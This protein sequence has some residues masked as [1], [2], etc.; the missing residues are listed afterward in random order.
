MTDEPKVLKW[1]EVTWV[2]ASGRTLVKAEDEGEAKML[3]SNEVEGAS[4]AGPKGIEMPEGK[5][6]AHQWLDVTDEEPMIFDMDELAED[7]AAELRR[8]MEKG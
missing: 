5:F 6:I 8:E 4:Q 3:A 2:T 7:T 1:Y